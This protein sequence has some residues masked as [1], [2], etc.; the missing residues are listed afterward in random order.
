MNDGKWT[1]EASRKGG[2]RTEEQEVSDKYKLRVGIQVR[3]YRIRRILVRS[4]LITKI[5]D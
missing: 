4:A 1:G 2:F 5:F 3:H